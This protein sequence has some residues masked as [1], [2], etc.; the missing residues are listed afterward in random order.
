M[1]LEEFIK[2]QI[3]SVDDLRTLLLLSVNSGLDWNVNEVAGKLYLLPATAG[4][5]LDRLT[6]KGLLTCSGEPPR[7][8]YQPASAEIA[9]LVSELIELD[10]KRPVTLINMVYPAKK[11]IQAF[12]DAFKIKRETEN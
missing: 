1:N 3:A 6:A 12:A 5:V 2:S 9:G 8:R 4:A 11:D 7:F 10:R